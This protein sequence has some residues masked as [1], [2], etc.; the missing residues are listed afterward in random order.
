MHSRDSYHCTVPAFGMEIPPWEPGT[1]AGCGYAG[2]SPG[3]ESSPYTCPLHQHREQNLPTVFSLACQK[4]NILFVALTAAKHIVMVF[5]CLKMKEVSE[6]DGRCWVFP[7]RSEH[8][9]T[10][11]S[12]IQIPSL[13]QL[14]PDLNFLTCEV[15]KDKH[16]VAKKLE[17][18]KGITF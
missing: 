5:L 12:W 4:G 15:K 13:P 7:R 10:A 9:T 6:V 11:Q 8:K 1:R 3:A 2:C 16:T 17:K 18:E 14:K